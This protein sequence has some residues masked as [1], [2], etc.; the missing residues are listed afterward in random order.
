MKA[1]T[2]TR[3]G[4]RLFNSP[5]PVLQAPFTYHLLWLCYLNEHILGVN[6]M[7]VS[8]GARHSPNSKL[9]WQL[10]SP[11]WYQEIETKEEIELLENLYNNRKELLDQHK[12]LQS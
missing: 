12:I 11:R 7:Q 6:M 2:E 5:F 10:V 8:R 1:S 9:L 3:Y 4:T